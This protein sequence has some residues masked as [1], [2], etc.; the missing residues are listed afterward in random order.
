MRVRIA[1]RAVSLVLA[2]GVIGSSGA[3]P[4]ESAAATTSSSTSVLYLGQRG[5]AVS[6]LQLE[7]AGRGYWLGPITGVFG[8][9]TQQAVFALQKAAGLAR[10]GVV[11][12]LT[13]AVLARGVRPVPRSTSGYVIEINLARNLLM[14]VR[15]GHLIVTLNTST[16]GGYAYAANGVSGVAVTPRGHFRLYRQVDGLDVSPLGE[17]WRPKYFS[18][19]YAI[20]GSDSVPAYPV[21]HG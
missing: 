2:L 13:R 9:L 14:L 17:L 11:G 6:K 15:D 3:P 7:L 10:D 18:S 21:S 16:G 20:H 1:W 8:D 5:P 19:G 12:P 4:V